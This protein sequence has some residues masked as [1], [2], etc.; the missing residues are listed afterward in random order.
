VEKREHIKKVINKPAVAL[1]F[2]GERE[3]NDIANPF[4]VFRYLYLRLRGRICCKNWLDNLNYISIVR[5]QN[6]L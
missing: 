2:R 6:M 3:Q 1:S 4:R 5:K